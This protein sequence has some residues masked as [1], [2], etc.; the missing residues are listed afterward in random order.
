M[1]LRALH[2]YLQR[3]T[4]VAL[5]LLLIMHYWFVHYT[6]GPIREGQISFELI[7]ER[8]SNPWMIAVNISFL[9]IALYHGLYG[10]RNIIFDYTWFGPRARQFITIALLLAGV[11]WAYWGITAFIGNEHL[12]QKPEAELVAV[13]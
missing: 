6:P 3:I 4:G 2:W 5:L 12:R 11:A 1:N 10:M 7:H 13:R 9:L 8:I